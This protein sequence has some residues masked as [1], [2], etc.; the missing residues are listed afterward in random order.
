MDHHNIIREPDLI[1]SQS[2]CR[3]TP[4]EHKPSFGRCPLDL[5]HNLKFTRNSPGL[6][7]TVLQPVNHLYCT[8]TTPPTHRNSLQNPH[9]ALTSTAS[10]SLHD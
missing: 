10:R 7:G 6:L 5:S 4:S 1:E 8:C 9:F 2:C 3:A